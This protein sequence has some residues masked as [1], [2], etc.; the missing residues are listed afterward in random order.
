MRGNPTLLQKCISSLAK[1]LKRIFHRS[2][3]YI[4]ATTCTKSF[5]FPLICAGAMERVTIS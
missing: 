5:G 2:I 4:P 1:L 3:N